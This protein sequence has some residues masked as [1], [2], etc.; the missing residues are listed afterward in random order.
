MYVFF[1]GL[2]F[3]FIGPN[4]RMKT[5]TQ[6]TLNV[7]LPVRPFAVVVVVVAV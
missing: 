4:V 6:F 3:I 7:V 1:N 5:H 2:G